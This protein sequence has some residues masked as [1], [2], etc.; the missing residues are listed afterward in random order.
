LVIS[1]FYRG[2]IPIQVHKSRVN[3]F[4]VYK[5]IKLSIY[6]LLLAYTPTIPGTTA[7]SLSNSTLPTLPPTTTPDQ[8]KGCPLNQYEWCY[9]VP[10]V[11]LWQ[12]I[13]ASV[14]ITMGFTVCNVICY[15][16]YSKKL[17]ERPQGTMMGIFTS[18]GSLARAIGPITVGFL[19]K[20][21]G[22]RVLMIFMLVVVFTGIL[23]LV[24]NF[25]RLYLEPELPDNFN[26]QEEN[27]IND[28]GGNDHEEN[29][30]NG[31]GGG[32]N[33]HEQNMINGDDDRLNRNNDIS[34]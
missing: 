5:S 3:Q 26:Y 15:S 25:R 6:F 2:V 21:W 4:F 10:I 7:S 11:K 27:R 20:H 23:V 13:L 19:Y 8:A 28:G 17:G 16:I 34:E 14:V 31:G 33:Y 9:Y 29:T 12:F 30:I 1:S 32:G 24:V 22:P 18:A